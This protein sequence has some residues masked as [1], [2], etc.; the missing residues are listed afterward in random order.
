MAS[1][2][3]MAHFDQ[4]RAE[5]EIERLREAIEAET[6]RCLDLQRKLERAG[7][8]YEEFVSMAAH[9]LLES[10]RGVASFS[11]LLGENRGGCLDPDA[12]VLIEHIQL[13][14]GRMQSLLADMVEYWATGLGD[15]QPC[16]TDMEAVLCQA[17]LY[18]NQRITERGASVSHDPLPAVMGHFATLAKVL[19]HLIRNAVEYAGTPSPHVHISSRR[20][21][22]DC[23]FSVHDDGVGIEPAFQ[24]RLFQ[25][26]TRLHGKEH[27]GDGLWLA[28]C[29]RAIESHG[30]RM[31]MESAPGAGTTFYFTLPSAE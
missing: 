19:H 2:L 16:R 8:E 29:R 23:V 15:R 17:L 18:T 30:G 6:R 11:Q 3:N 4:E 28:F 5:G 13:G 9:N 31:W 12:G 27:P 14:A 26:F 7:R 25:A 21:H 1:K 10:L 22:H 24:G 20:E